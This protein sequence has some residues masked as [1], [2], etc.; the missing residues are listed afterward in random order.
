MSLIWNRAAMFHSSMQNCATVNTS[1]LKVCLSKAI[2]L[3]RASQLN[4]SARFFKKSLNHHNSLIS[5]NPNG[6]TRILSLRRV[7]HRSSSAPSMITTE[8]GKAIRNRSQGLTLSWSRHLSAWSSTRRVSVTCL[9]HRRCWRLRMETWTLI[10]KLHNRGWVEAMYVW[11]QLWVDIN[12]R[13]A[14]QVMSLTY[15]QQK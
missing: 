7:W 13:L 8:I 6:I 5:N 11:S 3:M 9:D 12:S 14:G 1:S 4:H 10:I 15:R 2:I